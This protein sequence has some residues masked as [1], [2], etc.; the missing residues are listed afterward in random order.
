[1]PV[2]VSG[3]CPND[4]FAEGPRRKPTDHSRFNALTMRSGRRHTAKAPPARGA[5]M[6]PNS[7]YMRKSLGE[8][9]T[10]RRARDWIHASTEGNLLGRRKP[11]RRL[12]K[13]GLDDEDQAY[14]QGK[15]CCL[16]ANHT[17]DRFLLVEEKW[18]ERERPVARKP[19]WTHR[20][21]NGQGTP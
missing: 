21:Q 11:I 14:L 16:V 6:L 1:M 15:R 13:W 20:D 2:E 18:S 5:P 3:E 4:P 7:C 12:D 10:L 19:N 17:Q 9:A 8:I